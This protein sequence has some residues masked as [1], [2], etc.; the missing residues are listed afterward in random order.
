MKQ[1]LTLYYDRECPFCNRYAA[2]LELKQHYDL[3]LKNAREYYAEIDALCQGLDINEG[4][5][6]VTE[7]Q[8]LQGVDALRYLDRAI[9]KKGMLSRLHGIWNLKGAVSGALYKSIKLLR[10]AVLFLMGRNTRIR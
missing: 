1:K 7:E 6:V 5:I 3:E 2:F 9:E 8:C 10:K 4:L